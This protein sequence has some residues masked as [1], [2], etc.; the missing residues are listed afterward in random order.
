VV[1]EEVELHLQEVLEF[2][3][4]EDQEEQVQ[5]IVLQVVQLQRWRRRWWSIHWSNMQVQVE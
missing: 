2:Q 5:Q 1:V 3:V 4:Q